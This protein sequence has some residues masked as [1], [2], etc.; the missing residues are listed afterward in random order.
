MLSAMTEPCPSLSPRST[1]QRTPSKAQATITQA[2]YV[3]TSIAIVLTQLRLILYS[4]QFVI[5][6]VLVGDEV[7][8]IKQYVNSNGNVAW[9][10]VGKRLE[11]KGVNSNVYQFSGGWGQGS[12]QGG[13]WVLS[14]V[15]PDPPQ[16]PT[17]PIVGHWYVLSLMGTANDRLTFIGG[18]GGELSICKQCRTERRPHEHHHRSRRLRSVHSLGAIRAQRNRNRRDRVVHPQR[19][20]QCLQRPR[21]R[22]NVPYRFWLVVLAVPGALRRWCR[23]DKWNLEGDS[24]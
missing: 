5:A 12:W 24:R 16:K 17:H 18:Q 13:Q 11:P 3:L 7:R 23:H 4:L 1:K 2:A 14:G 9:K 6:G 8:F 20:T 15:A 21:R 19:H 10:Y 22:E